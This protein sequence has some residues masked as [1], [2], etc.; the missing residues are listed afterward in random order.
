[1][2]FGFSPKIIADLTFP[3]SFIAYMILTDRQNESLFLHGMSELS[4]DITP[5]IPTVQ[6]DPLTTIQTKTTSTIFQFPARHQLC[7]NASISI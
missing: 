4:I 3:G 5:G 1:M 6:S 2:S 7:Q